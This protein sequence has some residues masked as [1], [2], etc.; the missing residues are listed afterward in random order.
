MYSCT[1]MASHNNKAKWECQQTADRPYS[2][3]EVEQGDTEP[4]DNGRHTAHGSEH[5][6]SRQKDAGG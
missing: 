6:R 5:C 3:R 2:D 1:F 4:E